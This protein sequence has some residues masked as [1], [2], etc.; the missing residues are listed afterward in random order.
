MRWSPDFASAFTLL[1]F[2][3]PDSRVVVNAGSDTW[4]FAVN[5]EIAY[6]RWEIS[7]LPEWVEPALS[8]LGIRAVRIEEEA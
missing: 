5:D 2:D 7:E 3:D 6:G 4:E 8:T 1:V